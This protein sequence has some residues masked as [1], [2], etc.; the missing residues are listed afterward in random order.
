MTG[1]AI[2]APVVVALVL[3]S[4]LTPVE[5]IEVEN[6]VPVGAEV[7]HGASAVGQL[8]GRPLAKQMVEAFGLFPTIVVIAVEFVTVN[9]GD[10]ACVLQIALMQT[11]V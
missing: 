11:M 3:P 9:E 10:A 7:N 5:I 1:I 8:I 6:V 4:P 2:R